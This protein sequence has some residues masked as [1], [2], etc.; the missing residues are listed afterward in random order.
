MKI[1]VIGGANLDITATSNATFQPEDS[2]PG[3]VR[4]SFGGVGRNIAHNLS[5]LGDQITFL[6]VFGDDIFGKSIAE[7]CRT[8]GMDISACQTG[9]NAPNPCFASI[10]DSDGRMIGGIADMDTTNLITPDWLSQRKAKINEADIVVA[11]ANLQP[12]T[13][14]WLMDNCKAPLFL[15]AV[16]GPKSKRIAQAFEMAA[17]PRF[18]S[19]KYNRLEE[20]SL[21]HL[22]HHGRH[23]ISLGKDG[24]K[25]IDNQSQTQTQTF[26]AYPIAKEKIKNMTGAGDALFAGIIHKGPNTT[27][28]EAA[29]FGLR[30]AA[31]TLE[32]PEAINPE[33]KTIS[34]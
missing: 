33:L 30:C 32:S 27:I 26:P 24:L 11:E 28:E 15:D 3:R 7:S 18:H 5:L 29:K 17:H 10:N 13:I 2:N 12:Q 6:T 19:I 23:F 25:V 21:S 8:L 9:E 16:S 4:T 34:L 1:C 31:L 20:Q 22:Q 14:A